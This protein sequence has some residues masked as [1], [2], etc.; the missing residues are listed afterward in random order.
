MDSSKINNFI[1]TCLA[2]LAGR[3]KEILEG[4]YGLNGGECLTLAE[5]GSGYKLTRERVR[6][7]E[8]T[9]L[10]VMP[11]A[12]VPIGVAV[13]IAQAGFHGP[14]ASVGGP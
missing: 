6:Q 4:R 10:K 8:T 3:Q 5:L 12:A 7:I 14:Y 2:G 1:K 9:A 11:D 13:D